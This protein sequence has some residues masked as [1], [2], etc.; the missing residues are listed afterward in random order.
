LGEAEE[1]SHH[2]FNGENPKGSR[3]DWIMVDEKLNATEI[4]FDKV[5][6]DGIYPS[7]HFPLKA[8]FLF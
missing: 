2:S 5:R 3:I 8:T 4:F 6:R 1:S 7:D